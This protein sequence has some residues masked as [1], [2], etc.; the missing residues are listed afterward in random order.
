MRCWR[1]FVSMLLIFKISIRI[2]GLAER[3]STSQEG[4]YRLNR[5]T[6]RTFFMLH[7]LLILYYILYYLT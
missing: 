3:L 5:Q 6:N 7:S 1:G 4:L 2:S